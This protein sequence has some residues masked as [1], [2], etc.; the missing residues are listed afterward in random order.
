M[1]RKEYDLIIKMVDLAI[2]QKNFG[3]ISEVAA[4]LLPL[5]K[6]N[7]CWI[8][9]VLVL[10]SYLTQSPAHIWDAINYARAAALVAPQQTALHQLAINAFTISANTLAAPLDRV[11]AGI[12]AALSAPKD[13]V[14]NAIAVELILENV[15]ALAC[16]EQ[17]IRALRAAIYYAAEKSSLKER[18]EK[19]LKA[20]EHKMG[21][22]R[23]TLSGFVQ[24]H[25]MAFVE[26]MKP[27]APP[28][29][30]GDQSSSLLMMD[31]DP[32]NQPV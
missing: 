21:D 11:E 28:R 2:A 30:N 9:P 5:M 27:Q 17:R 1:K 7:S 20:L 29:A 14:L 31:A 19:E 23:M 16:D 18:A 24:R 25:K 13:S 22:M 32:E 10:A 15:P 8:E 4:Q 6:C 3:K 26:S 12:A